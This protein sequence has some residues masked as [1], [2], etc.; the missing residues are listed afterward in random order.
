MKVHDIEGTKPMDI[1]CCIIQM[2][3]NKLGR[4]RKYHDDGLVSRKKFHKV[5]VKIEFGTTWAI[6]VF[7]ARVL[8]F[9]FLYFL[10]SRYRGHVYHPFVPGAIGFRGHREKGP[11]KAEAR[12]SMVFHLFS[13]ELLEHV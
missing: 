9:C 5:Q 1:A 12:V 3:Q 7:Y 2:R 13:M 11:E 8:N 10:L 4:L 6:D